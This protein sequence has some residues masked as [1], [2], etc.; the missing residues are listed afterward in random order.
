MSTS[1]EV[2]AT[3]R[4]LALTDLEWRAMVELY[5]A[6]ALRVAELEARNAEQE[7][8][9]RA[10]LEEAECRVTHWRRTALD[11][12]HSRCELRIAEFEGVLRAVK[13]AVEERG[14]VEGICCYFCG[15]DRG[16]D[17]ITGPEPHRETCAEL[18]IDR[19]LA[20]APPTA[21]PPRAVTEEEAASDEYAVTDEAIA[22]GLR[23]LEEHRDRPLADRIAFL[24]Q[25]IRLTAATAAGMARGEERSRRPTPAA[26][27]REAFKAAAEAALRTVTVPN[28]GDPHYDDGEATLDAAAA[29]ILKLAD[30]PAAVQKIV[31]AARMAP[32]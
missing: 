1:A 7:R 2:L 9:A 22:E 3:A 6:K 21:P 16:K 14:P 31:E 23:L 26:V 24:G 4:A 15:A 13:N 12:T 30:N 28:R 27:V 17:L 8:A 25:V 10:E 29:V 5:D 19:A 32:A 20:G 11:R 18:V